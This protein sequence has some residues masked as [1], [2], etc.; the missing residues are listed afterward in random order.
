M[1]K[2]PVHLSFL[3]LFVLTAATAWEKCQ[4]ISLFSVCLCWQPLLHEKSAST[5]LF[6]L[7]V[8]ADSRY[9][10]R[11]VPV[12]LSFLCL[13]VLTAATAWEKCQYISLFSVCLCWQP[14]L[15]GKSASTSLFSLFVCADSRYCMRKVPVHLSFLCLFVLTAATAWEKCQYI[16]LFSVCLCW[17]PLLH[18]KSASTSLFSLFVCADS[19][20]CMRKVPVHL[21]FLCLFV[22]TAATAWEKCQ[23]ISLFSVC[24]CWQPLLHEKSASTSL[25]SLFVLTAATAWEKC[26]Y[27]SL[28]SVC[29]CWQ[30]LLHEKSASTSLFSLFVLT[31]TAAWEQCQHVSLCLYVEW[32]PL[33]LF[34]SMSCFGLTAVA[35]GQ[36]DKHIWHG[37]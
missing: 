34:L 23:Y 1:R 30:P 26:Q 7:F 12:H 29:L 31:A 13:F 9:C 3:C 17:Q 35:A 25:F 37:D 32:S 4:Y 2:V 33:F 27:I 14:L 22:L 36:Q 6:S 28:F 18:E 5:S 8:C 24:L 10:M 19:R 16:S 21:S 20:Y 15:H 11:K